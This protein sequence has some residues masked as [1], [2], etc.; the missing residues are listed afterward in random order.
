MLL[1][2]S[3][4]RQLRRSVVLHATFDASTTMIER[5]IE[6]DTHAS[7][8]NPIPQ[9]ANI[10]IVVGVVMSVN[11]IKFRAE[12]GLLVIDFHK[13]APVLKKKRMHLT[14]CDG[15][16]G[17]EAWRVEVNSRWVMGSFNVEVEQVLVIF[18]SF[19]VRK[20]SRS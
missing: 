9:S 19:E 18:G 1:L 7:E 6:K 4:R 10:F 2:A 5:P 8:L 17:P 15:S 13:E 16:G 14:P 12:E 20:V 3:D 11:A